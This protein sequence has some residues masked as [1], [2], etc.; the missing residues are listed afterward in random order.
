MLDCKTVVFFANAVDADERSGASVKRLARFTRLDHVYGTVRL[1]NRVEERLHVLRSSRESGRKFR[2][3]S[4][5]FADC[6]KDFILL[7]MQT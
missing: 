3:K 4:N 7:P 5:S 1:P 6:N 2:I